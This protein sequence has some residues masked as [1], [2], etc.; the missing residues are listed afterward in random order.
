M[1]CLPTCFAVVTP[2]LHLPASRICPCLL[3]WSPIQPL[4]CKCA[5]WITDIWDGEVIDTLK[6]R[7]PDFFGNSDNLVLFLTADGFLPFGKPGAK[8]KGKKKKNVT[9]DDVYDT[10]KK[11]KGTWPLTV[12]IANL[13]PWLRAKLGAS[14]PL[15]IT[16]MNNMHTIE[17]F[18][19]PLIDELMV[20]WED[21]CLL[22]PAG[23]LALFAW[24]WRCAGWW[25]SHTTAGAEVECWAVGSR[26]TCE[27][28]TGNLQSTHSMISQ[29]GAQHAI[30]Q[31]QYVMYAIVAC[32]M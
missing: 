16:P 17:P 26:Q 2:R 9:A 19:E 3:A 24:C 20:L 23:K 30:L 10:K 29:L 32:R 4:C 13:P 18:L 5:E 8:Q 6:R 27:G 31:Q 15:G 21:G 28:S 14:A 22:G 7:H 1:W 12:T 11:G 25:H